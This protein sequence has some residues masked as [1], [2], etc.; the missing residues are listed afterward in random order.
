MA[1]LTVL[2]T[3]YTLSEVMDVEREILAE[4]DAELVPSQCQTE[5]DL[6]AHPALAVCD[7][8]ITQ[9][10]PLTRRVFEQATRCRAVSR[11]GIGVDRIDLAAAQERGIAVFNCPDYCIQEVAEHALALALD[12]CRKITFTTRMVA[13]GQWGQQPL[14]PIHRLETLT[15]GVAGMGR[16]GQAVAQRAQPFFRRVIG[17]DPYA[18]EAAFAAGGAEP[19]E[20]EE[21]FREANVLTLH[22]PFTEE[23]RHLVRA[24][25]LATMP[26]GSFLVNTCRGGV[27]DTQALLD[28]LSSGQLAGAGLDVFDPEPLPE[29][30]PLRERD[31]VLLTPHVAWY[32]VEANED[33]RV[34]TSRNL[35][36]FFQGKLVASR[37]V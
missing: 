29:D 21:L 11:D 23:T 30:H 28:A 18:S 24:E 8:M 20:R 6:L 13:R 22:V 16:I 14:V 32:S 1:K 9:W 25:T 4:I 3:D 31:D 19:V 26:E 7:A 27:V 34:K 33:D 15:C 37:L 35:V 36:D 2:V 17:W 12:L 5:E 10:A